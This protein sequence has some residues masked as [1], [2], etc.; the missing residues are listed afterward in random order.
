MRE[1]LQ[2][3]EQSQKLQLQFQQV[4]SSCHLS[5][6][7]GAALWYRWYLMVSRQ[8]YCITCVFYF[9]LQAGESLRSSSISS[10]A[11]DLIQARQQVLFYQQQLG[12]RDTKVRDLQTKLEEREAKVKSL[13][14]TSLH[15]S[16]LQ[17]KMSAAEA[18]SK[19]MAF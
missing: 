3:T 14:E 2:L 12:E 13:E 1:F 4:T 7:V 15:M 5:E 8:L 17:Q 10:T 9:Q 19:L 6:V 16:Q 18:V 11:A